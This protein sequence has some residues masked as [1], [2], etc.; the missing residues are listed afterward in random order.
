MTKKISKIVLDSDPAM[1]VLWTRWI[2]FYAGSP[3]LF[4]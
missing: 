1:S 2:P 4:A 3:N